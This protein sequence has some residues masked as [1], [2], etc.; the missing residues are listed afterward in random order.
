MVRSEGGNF[1][2][3]VGKYLGL[4][5]EKEYMG[6]RWGG[7]GYGLGGGIGGKGGWG[8]K[9]VICFWGDGGL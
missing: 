8:D 1:Y 7:M 2:G 3:W 9:S 6:P 5:N 4:R